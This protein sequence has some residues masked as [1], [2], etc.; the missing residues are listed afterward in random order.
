MSAADAATGG[1][2]PVRPAAG[3]DQ[4]VSRAPV[5]WLL[6]LMLTWGC[7]GS[8][9]MLWPAVLRYPGAMLVATVAFAVY[10]VPFLL[11]ITDI[12][13]LEPEPRWLMT[14]AFAWGGGVA[15]TAAVPGVAALT[16]LLAKATS[17]EFA[18]S[19]GAALAAPTIEEPVKLLGVVMIA[20]V[21][22]RE[23][24]SII[25]GLVYG[26]V[27]GLGFQVVED[28]TYAAN[29]VDA[30]PGTDQLTPVLVTLF[31]RGF[32]S[33]LWS[34]TVFTALAGAGVA[35][36]L[37][38]RGRRPL[39][40]RLGIAAICFAGA[41]ICHFT[42]NS[43]LLT[44]GVGR[45]A[46][47]LIKGVPPLVLVLALTKT[48][49]HREAEYYVRLLERLGDPRIASR[50][51]LVAL[52]SRAGRIHARAAACRRAGWRPERLWLV[53]TAVRVHR[54]MHQL[55]RAQARLAVALSRTDADRHDHAGG[56]DSALVRQARRDVLVARHRL[57]ATGR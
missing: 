31:A 11:F 55:Q 15:M 27:V 35:H 43:P 13:Y 37:V 42:W 16:S 20:L 45:L 3:P 26:A 38:H 53:G 49:G 57:I 32:V 18:A 7:C 30:Y 4:R 51:E 14:V 8:V 54:A 56:P 1:Q 48:A 41:W 36:V 24:N 44:G 19:W 17:P 25:D 22:G 46:E 21:A 6:G 39:W 33:G 10:A 52:G 2:Q 9:L 47:L 50:D 40:R 12:D 5:T 29:A 34:H 28:I 23:V